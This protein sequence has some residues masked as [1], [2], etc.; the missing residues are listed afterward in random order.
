MR[1][2]SH[3]PLL[4]VPLF[5]CLVIGAIGIILAYGESDRIQ[6]W[7]K[8]LSQPLPSE[9]VSDLCTRSL[10]PLAIGDCQ[11]KQLEIKLSSIP[12]IFRANLSSDATSN[13]VN[14]LFGVYLL[15]C[16]KDSTQTNS[17]RC[18]YKL[19]NYIFVINY[20]TDTNKVVSMS[21]LEP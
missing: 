17:V 6:G 13:D 11:N 19:A 21:F 20:S 9:V 3:Y 1:F 8:Y 4:A 5:I 10:V 2:K 7:E 12:D 18:Q 16:Q 14:Q 15:D